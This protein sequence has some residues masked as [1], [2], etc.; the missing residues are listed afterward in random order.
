YSSIPGGGAPNDI[1]CSSRRWRGV[2]PGSG[3]NRSSAAIASATA[4]SSHRGWA[5]AGRAL[6]TR[7]LLGE[8]RPGVQ[9]VER[10]L[11]LVVVEPHRLDRF[12]ALLVAQPL[13]QVAL[14]R[15]IGLLEIGRRRARL[16]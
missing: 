16:H 5:E 13:V 4:P 2:A 1:S 8:H 6:L 12:V 15:Q 10:H 14:A 3:E 9:I 11:Q 7:R